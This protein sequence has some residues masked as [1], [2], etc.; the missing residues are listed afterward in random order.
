MVTVLGQNQYGKAEVRIVRVSRDTVPHR[1]KDLTVGIA[2]SGDLAATHLT[3]DNSAVLPTDTAKNTVYALARQHGIACIEEYGG[4]L[5]RHFVDTQPAIHRARVR[6]E[7]YG[8]SPIASPAFPHSFVRDGG[9]VRT[10]EVVRDGSGLRIVSGVTG[11]I[12]MNTT[13]SEFRGYVKD[14]YTT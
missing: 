6:I 14:R 5:A 10:T 12:V 8:W 7:E 9:E 13:A 1:V 4:L 11:L 2:L 3:G